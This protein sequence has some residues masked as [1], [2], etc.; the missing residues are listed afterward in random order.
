MM[1]PPLPLK[2]LQRWMQTVITHPKGVA[3]GIASDAARREI[4]VS[5]ADVE[6][7]IGPSH[8]LGSIQRLEI[9]GNAYY[10]RLIECLTAEFPATRHLVGEEA[11]SGFVLEYLQQYPSTSDT[12]GDLGAQFPQYLAQARPPREGEQPDW[13]DFLIDLATLERTYSDVFDGPGEEGLPLLSAD[14]LREIP[15]GQWEQVRLVTAS[16]LRLVELRFP[17]HEYASAVRGG[18]EPTIPPASPTRLAINRGDYIVRRRTF[19]ELPFAI[20]QRLAD[21]QTLGEAIA[22]SVEAQP[23]P[24]SDLAAPLEHWFR[25]W[26]AAGY[27]ADVELS[28]RN[29][30]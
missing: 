26:T 24:P 21:R 16:S 4:D 25:M 6:H 9:Y 10:A 15:P 14:R 3:A 29:C 11:F 30:A 7:V 22:D 5:A 2:N 8:A 23:Q 13:A 12:L 1:S 27:F 19:E 28:P 18:A 17:V 20:L